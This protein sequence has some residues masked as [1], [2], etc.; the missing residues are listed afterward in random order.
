MTTQ[1]LDPA[2][3]ELTKEA[4][5]DNEQQLIHK[6]LVTRACVEGKRFETKHGNLLLQAFQSWQKT[7]CYSAGNAVNFVRDFLGE[8]TTFVENMEI[9]AF[10]DGAYGIKAPLLRR[11]GCDTSIIGDRVSQAYKSLVFNSDSA[12]KPARKKDMDMSLSIEQLVKLG[13][14]D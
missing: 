13:L 2:T 10:A 5:E 1:L 11:M 12:T 6:D 4:T 8:V 14:G 3:I 7:E 9:L